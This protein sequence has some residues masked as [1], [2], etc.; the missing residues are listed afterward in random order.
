M[1]ADIT[2]PYAV[3]DFSEIRERGFYYVDKTQFITIKLPYNYGLF[4]L[5]RV[6]WSRCLLIIATVIRF[7]VSMSF[8]R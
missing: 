2:I 3:A 7:I 4:D 5:V 1:I 6:C 8:G